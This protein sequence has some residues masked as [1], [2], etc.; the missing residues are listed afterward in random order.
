MLRRTLHAELPTTA[1]REPARSHPEVR[2]V[3]EDQWSLRVTVDAGFR[4]DLETLTALLSH[5][6]PNGDLAA[7]LREGIR[8]GIE[9]HGKRKGAVPP[10]REGRSIAEPKAGGAIPASVRREVWKRDGGVCTWQGDGGRRCGSRW[11]VEPDHVWPAALGGPST[12]ENLRLLCAR[13]NI[14]H[15]EQVYG[16]EHMDLFRRG[17]PSPHMATPLTP[18]EGA[19]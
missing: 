16:R 7:V 8:C 18:P 12:V 2:P 4:V 6:V 10:V 19:L 5:K 14:L 3:S 11:Q 15:A 9:K 17:S 1:P 13:H